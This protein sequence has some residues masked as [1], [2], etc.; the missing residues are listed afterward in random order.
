MAVEI[1]FWRRF[2]TFLVIGV[3]T[4][5]FGCSSAEK[6]NAPQPVD[7][8]TSPAVESANAKSVV[9]ATRHL[10]AFDRA[11][12]PTVSGGVNQPVFPPQTATPAAALPKGEAHF[13]QTDHA[14]L[15]RVPVEPGVHLSMRLPRLARDPFKL[16]ETSSG[17]S[18]EA[19]LGG[20]GSSDGEVADGY[21]VYEGALAGAA[22]KGRTTVPDGTLMLR[23][24]SSGIE[25]YM[26]FDHAPA[27]PEVEYDVALGDRV[28]GLRMLSDVVEFLDAGGAPRL[29]LALPKIVGADGVTHVA[30]ASIE[31][32]RYDTNPAAPWGRPVTDPGARRCTIRIAWDE[33]GLSYPALFD[34]QWVTTTHLVAARG[35]HTVTPFKCSNGDSCLLI[36][37]GRNGTSMISPANSNGPSTEIYDISSNPPSTATTGEMHI[38]RYL[39]TATYIDDTGDTKLTGGP[40]IRI[41]VV[42]GTTTIAGTALRYTE[43]YNPATG[44]WSGL[45]NG[46]TASSCATTFQ[47]CLHTARYNHTA[48]AIPATVH[49]VPSVVVTG[50]WPANNQPPMTSVEIYGRNGTETTMTWHTNWN[51]T[52]A[53]L[54][55]PR[56]LHAATVLDNSSGN[57]PV[58]LI[59]GGRTD[60][61]G[62]TTATAEELKFSG[63]NQLLQT[64][65]ASMSTQRATFPLV[66]VGSDWAVA[67]GGYGPSGAINSGEYFDGSTWHA[68]NGTLSAARFRFGTELLRSSSRVLVASGTTAS[69]SYLVNSDVYDKA[70]N[71]F[72]RASNLNTPRMDPGV[73]DMPFFQALPAGGVPFSLGYGLAL[74]GFSPSG[75]TATNAV[76]KWT[77]LSNGNACTYTGDCSSLFCVDGYCCNSACGGG[78]DT[79]NQS[80][81]HGTCKAV[82]AGAAGSPSCSP[83]L[84]DGVNPS[85]PSTCSAD[86][87]CATGYYCNASGTCAP[88]K[89]LGT[90][91]NDSAGYDCY[92]GGCRVCTGGAGT[93]ADGVCCNSACSGSCDAC[94]LSGKVGQCTVVGA[95]TAGSP[96]CSGNLLCN[97]SSASCPSSCSSNADCVSGYYC[98][99]SSHTCKQ[100]STGTPC[101]TANDCPSN[102]FCADGVC[103]NSTCTGG[104]SRCDLSGKVGTCSAVSAG[105]AP[106]NCASSTGYLC[107]GTELGCPTTCVK[108]ADCASGYYCASDSTCKPQKSQGSACNSGVGGDCLVSGCRVCTTGQ[109]VDG[110]CC[111]TACSAACDACN[112]AGKVGTCSPVGAGQAGTPSCAPYTCGSGA[113]CA[114]TCSSNS[115]CA[116]GSYC[117]SNSHCVAQAGTGAACTS[118]AQC[119]SGLTCVDGVC[120]TTDCTGTCMACSAAKKGSGVDGYCGPIAANSDPD[121][122]CGNTPA[123]GCGT[124]GMCDGAGKCAL[125]PAGTTCGTGTSCTNGVESGYQCDGQGNCKVASTTS[126]A[127]YVCSGATCGAQCA[128]DTDCSATTYCDTAT[129]KC[130]AKQAP[131]AACTGTDQCSSGFCVDGVCCDK[132]CSGTCYACTKAKKGTGDDGTCGPIAAGTDPDNECPSDPVSTCQRN[133]FCDGAGTCGFYAVGTA[134][135]SVSCVGNSA[136]GKVCNSFNECKDSATGV[137]CDPYICSSGGCPGSCTDSTQCTSGFFCSAGQCVTQKQQGDTCTGDG[138]CKSQHCAD[139]VCCNDAC[140]G[141][142]QACDLTGSVGTCTAFTGDPAAHDRP[143]CTGTG[144]CAGTCDGNNT[145]TCTYPDSTTLC[146]GTACAGNVF[147]PK[148]CDGQGGCVD[149]QSKDC[150]NY[151]CDA[152]AGACKTSCKSDTDCA[153]GSSCNTTTGQCAAQSSTCKNATTVQQANGQEQ[154]C[155]PYRCVAGACQQQCSSSSDCAPGYD[156]QSSQCVPAPDAGSDAGNPSSGAASSNNTG[157]CGCSVPH[158]SGPTPLFAL[159]G[160]LFVVFERRR[161]SSRKARRRVEMP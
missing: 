62:T 128:S 116:A 16:T 139:G 150:G 39:H 119:N 82:S 129:N 87:D 144:K 15:P 131:G 5:A 6:S 137:A 136:V 160:L 132:A 26:V 104:C 100:Q 73:P 56:E 9:Q 18:V 22:K 86:S 147:Q 58:L 135:G 99:T 8:P 75:V 36:A 38:P 63:T 37:G 67:I 53:S 126:C 17:V 138:D 79:C 145:A 161:R 158:R 45:A 111:N 57:A 105:T 114:T 1:P 33:K 134:C 141:Q 25:D 146:E 51:G 98:D 85:C 106:A 91:C 140:N 149:G 47:Y 69:Y 102:L 40:A 11:N 78:C 14:Y 55:T 52:V 19:A 65:V 112:L 155:E 70:T 151:A 130:V 7:V 31:G 154:S 115:D 94:N 12:V 74:G 23:P 3:S 90:A 117:D 32:C 93:C 81:S 110:A 109:C 48:T 124:N 84:C 20:A 76:E 97:G 143:A 24:F 21:A 72:Y 59:A 122:E 68:V 92:V 43:Y 13:E 60:N 44:A 157:G 41:L 34:P 71:S 127:P 42:G 4:L 10:F 142:C 101:Q 88:V 103:C 153:S 27:R 50:G 107:N 156:C 148:V 77:T 125:W 29:R 95:G 123:S 64:T 152:T 133:G 66:A 159:G 61:T 2:A 35:Q 28:A 49:S 89:G 120:C 46:S 96:A 118:Q 121:S 113:S 54:G 80:G 108:D 30:T 83:Y